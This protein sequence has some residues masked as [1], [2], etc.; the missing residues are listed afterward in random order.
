VAAA[1]AQR[2]C[3]RARAFLT[4]RRGARLRA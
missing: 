2:L 1:A 3:V 4:R